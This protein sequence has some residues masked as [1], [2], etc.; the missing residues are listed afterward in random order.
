MSDDVSRLHSWIDENRDEMVSALQGVL[1]IPSKKEAPAGPDAPYGAPLR[2]AL[3]YT[4]DLAR[5][6]GFRVRDVDGHAGHAEWGQGEEMVAA[7]GHLDVVP[8][9]DRW[10]HPPYGAEI[11]GGFIY[12]RGASDDKGPSYAAL[13]AAKAV[14]ESGLPISRRIR[15]IFGC[16]EESGFGCVHHYWG[17]AKEERPVSAFTPDAYFPLIYAE[18]GIATLVL[19]RRR[20]AGDERG[21][22]LRLIRGHGGL[23][24][25]MVP[26]HAEA[27][28]EGEPGSL[29]PALVLLLRHWDRNLKVEADETGISL[30]AVGKSAHGSTPQDGDNAVARLA[31]ALLR[32]DLPEDRPW[33]EWVTRSA[34]PTG[35]GLGIQARD[36]VAGALTNN[37][38]VF[39]LTEETVRITYNIRYPVT[40]TVDHLL[41][42]CKPILESAGWT[43]AHHEDSPPLYVPLDE[44]PVRTLLR[45]YREETGDTESMP[46]TMGGGTYARATPHAVAFGAGFP[47]GS[48]GPAHEPDERIAIESLVKAAKIYARSLYELAR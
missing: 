1:R 17:A 20:P 16:D 4:L 21:G 12:A 29:Y 44:E 13:F 40:W 27:R 24:S 3:D 7:M 46:G 43:L 15:V 28:L 23:R 48:D 10:Q 22:D 9:G 41:D 2:Q 6:L 18:K 25:N 47:G 45:V 36:D 32:C 33:L 30:R 38:G 34:D 11:D 8:E 31:H 37:L 42:R 14:M 19:E 39:A 26:D 35:A 5:R